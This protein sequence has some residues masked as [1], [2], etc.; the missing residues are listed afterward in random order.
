LIIGVSLLRLRRPATNAGWSPPNDVQNAITSDFSLFTRLT[1]LLIVLSPCV[2]DSCE[3]ILPPSC[4]KRT[5]NALQ[6][7]WK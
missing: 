2:N 1:T 3:T 4:V 6:S 7:S 5:V